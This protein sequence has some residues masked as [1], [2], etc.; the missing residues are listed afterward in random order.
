MTNTYKTQ[1]EAYN[2]LA[3]YANEL[4]P[5]LNKDRKA[6]KWRV[7]VDELLFKKN[8]EDIKNIKDSVKNPHGVQCWVRCTGYGCFMVGFQTSYQTSTYAC[9]YLNENIY[10]SDDNE[11]KKLKTIT[12][13]KLE[14]AAKRLRTLEEKA[15][16]IK[17][18]VSKLKVL[19]NK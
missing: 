9:A 8:A 3:K 4:V 15:K 11:P 14:H 5:L 13:E 12:P 7:T 6:N 16:D 10:L 2:A 1:S 19:L 18:E 17:R